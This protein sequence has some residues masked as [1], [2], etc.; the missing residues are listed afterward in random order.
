MNCTISSHHDEPTRLLI[1][2][3]REANKAM[4]DPESYREL[5]RFLLLP[6]RHPIEYLTHTRPCTL[7]VGWK[8]SWGVL[9]GGD[10]AKLV[11]P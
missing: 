5:Y 10:T 11:D 3:Q 8:L 7:P 2:Y 4:R 1:T 6:L 9:V